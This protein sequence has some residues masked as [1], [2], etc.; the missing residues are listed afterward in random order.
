MLLYIY[1]GEL[2]ANMDITKIMSKNYPCLVG[3]EL[4]GVHK[5]CLQDL[6]FF[7]HLPSSVYI[8][9]GIKVYKKSI[10]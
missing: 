7:D 3:I 10:F 5:L 2:I 1:L 6:A 9:Y 8:F 4:G